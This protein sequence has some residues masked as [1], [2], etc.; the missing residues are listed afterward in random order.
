MLRP[1]RIIFRRLFS[2]SSDHLKPYGDHSWVFWGRKQGT[3]PHWTR[4][5]HCFNSWTFWGA[6]L[7]HLRCHLDAFGESS[8]R[9][10][11]KTHNVLLWFLINTG[12]C[13]F[14]CLVHHLGPSCW[15][16]AFFSGLREPAANFAPGHLGSNRAKNRPEWVSRAPKIKNLDSPKTLKTISVLRFLG[17]KASPRASRWLQ[18]WFKTHTKMEPTTNHEIWIFCLFF[19]VLEDILSH[20]RSHLDTLGEALGPKNLETSEFF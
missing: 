13:H 12:L 6:I 7:S 8:G 14:L 20:L 2:F 18:K 1:F 9:K 16:L 3:I 19:L 15:N 17:A 10:S 5:A 4:D 11:L